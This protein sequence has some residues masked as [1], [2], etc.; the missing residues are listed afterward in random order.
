MT[1]QTDHIEITTLVSRLFR[2]LDARKFA[3][4]WADGYFTGD[5]RMIAPVGVY[6]GPAAVQG[7]EEAVGRFARTQHMASD[8]LTDVDSA[9]GTARA[10]WN[11]L[12]VHLH[13]EGPDPL[14]TVG[15]RYEA[16]LRRTD[17]GWRFRRMSVEAV[18]TTGRPPVLP[19]A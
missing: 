1:P 12:M 16:D 6:D 10:S 3:D 2:A 11:A 4:G 5:I 8:V 15:G 19:S 17:D 14:F 9:S 7:T 13:H 18:W